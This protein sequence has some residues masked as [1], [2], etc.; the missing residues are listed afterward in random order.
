VH[1]TKRIDLEVLQRELAAA[2]VPTSGLGKSGTDQDGEV[3]TYDA[4][5]GII[6]LPPEATPVVNAHTAPPLVTEFAGSI[7]VSAITRTTDATPREVFRFPCEQK[8][9][10][11]ASLTVSGV[12]AVSG[13]SKIME[14]RFTWKRPGAVAVV[15]GLTVVSDIH[16]AAAA[17]WAPNYAA[18][19]T[20]VVFTVTGAAGRT[21]DWLLQGTV[22]AYAPEGL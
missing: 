5:G 10:Y 11:Q 14:G 18:V 8:H 16:D 6:D 17:S 19:G 22:G 7:Q 21:V 13:A 20:D 1:V 4:G 12:D 3:Y 9:L 15:V 2:S